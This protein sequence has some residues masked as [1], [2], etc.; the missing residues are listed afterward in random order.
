[1]LRLGDALVEEVHFLLHDSEENSDVLSYYIGDNFVGRC[2][3]V[4]RQMI[5]L[6]DRLKSFV[7]LASKDSHNDDDI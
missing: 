4:F 1:M 6:S 2:V 5:G 3:D 7:Y